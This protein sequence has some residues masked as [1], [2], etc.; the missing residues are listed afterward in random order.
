ALTQSLA[1][2]LGGRDHLLEP[3]HLRPQDGDLAVCPSERVG[4]ESAPFPPV[5][6]VV[7]RLA[8]TGARGLVLQELADLGER[9]AGVVAEGLD[10]PEPFDVGRVIEAIRALAASGRVEEANLLVVANGPG[11]QAQ[12]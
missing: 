3:L 1:A 12:L 6:G 7:E 5:R 10:E 11:R 9:E 4:H 8:R 2:N